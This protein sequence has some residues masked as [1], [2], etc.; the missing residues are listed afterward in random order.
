MKLLFFVCWLVCL[1]EEFRQRVSNYVKPKL[2][3]GE[4]SLFNT[5]KYLYNDAE[6]VKIIEEVFLK[7]EVNLTKSGHFEENGTSQEQLHLQSITILHTSS[8]THKL[9]DRHPKCNEY[10]D[11]FNLETGLEEPTQTILWV[12]M[13]LAQHYNKLK[14]VQRA[15]EYVDKAIKHTP[16]VIDLYVIKGCIYQVRFFFQNT[17]PHNVL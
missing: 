12:W 13:F 2:V 17:T 11:D 3:K 6:K 10:N 1:G 7:F 14:N 9:I 4:P 8:V 16:T 15:L 5:L